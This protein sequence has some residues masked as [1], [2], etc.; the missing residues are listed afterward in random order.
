MQLSNKLERAI[1]PLN[2]FP[3]QGI[4]FHA[5]MDIYAHAFIKQE[6]QDIFESGDSNSYSSIIYYNLTI[7]FTINFKIFLG[8]KYS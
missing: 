3:Q 6:K 8:V 4:Q 7:H 5:V 1:W 2:C